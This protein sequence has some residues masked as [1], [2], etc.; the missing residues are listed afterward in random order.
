MSS[1]RQF[2]AGRSAARFAL[3]ALGAGAVLAG[4]GETPQEPCVTAD[5]RPPQLAIQVGDTLRLN[6]RT[7]AAC[8]TVTRDFRTGRVA[9]V[10]NRAIVVADLSNPA[11]GFTDAEYATIATTFDT[12]VYP[13][14]VRNFGAPT[15]LDRNG[16]VVIFYTRAVNELTPAN[17]GFVVGGFFWNR[18]LFPRRA[19]S[20][21]NDCPGSND[22]ELFYML[23]PDPTG[24]ING[25]QRSKQSVLNGTVA[26]IAHEFQHLINASRRLYVLRTS[27]FD[28]VTWLNEGLSHV[29]EELMFYESAGYS[30]AGQPGESPRSDLTITDVRNQPGAIA[31]LNTFNT[32][33]LSR[34]SRYLRVTA[35]SSPYAENDNLATRGGAWAFLRYAAD[36]TGQP[37]SVL[38]RKLVNSTQ[39]GLENLA[40]ATGAGAALPDWFRDWAVAN[41]ADGFVQTPLDPRFQYTSWQFRSVLAALNANNGV[42]PLAINPLAEGQPR[43]LALGGGM[44]AYFPFTVA[45]GGQATVSTRNGQALSPQMRV[46]LVRVSTPDVPG[47]PAVTTFPAGEGADVTVSNPAAQA[48]QYALVV[49]NSSTNPTVQQAVSVTATGLAAPALASTAPLLARAGAA[50]AGPS[51]AR[52]AEGASATPIFS[53][54]ALHQRLRVIGARE[55][56][57]RVPAARA[58]YQARR[59]AGERQ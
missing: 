30:P 40:A 35:D 58:T 59:A 29:A 39:L 18:D 19:T 28:E 23:A 27:S 24:Q 49:F 7:D 32:Q 44:A 25:N 26:V 9:A 22:A 17:S 13:V 41:Y 20:R 34:F 54:A 57:R 45:A 2:S 37:D 50:Q 1:S 52:L 53:D 47:G 38:F 3:C 51:L 5:C 43:L 31:A 8:D 16:R 12:L 55:L 42:Y 15:D 46:S 14:D 33:N 11:G 10:S 21:D 36:R 6:A 48:S 56:A 4:C